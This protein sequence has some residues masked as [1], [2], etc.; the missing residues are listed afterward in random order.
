MYVDKQD[1]HAEFYVLNTTHASENA[2]NM[3]KIDIFCT[4]FT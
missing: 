3:L 2:G 4:K 1:L